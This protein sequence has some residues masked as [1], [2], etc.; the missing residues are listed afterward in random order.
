MDIFWKQN[1][2]QSRILCWTKH[3]SNIY[4]WNPQTEIIQPKQ[5]CSKTNT[6]NSC[7]EKK[8]KM[9]QGEIRC[10]KAWQR[11]PGGNALTHARELY[12]GSCFKYTQIW[13][14]LNGFSRLH[15]YTHMHVHIC[16]CIHVHFYVCLCVYKEV[17]NL[18]VIG[19]EH[20][21]SRRREREDWNDVNTVLVY[22]I[23]KNLKNYLQKTTF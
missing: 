5:N 3:V 7:S 20:G 13:I 11:A 21:E 1:A 14:L 19:M 12:S 10:L 9:C 2:H 4:F 8:R 6:T 23:L 15:L 16:M 22:R 17:M 18:V